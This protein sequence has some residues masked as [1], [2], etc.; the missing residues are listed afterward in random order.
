MYKFINGYK[1]KLIK[2]NDFIRCVIHGE[3]EEGMSF[4][5][6]HIRNVNDGEHSVN[7]RND[8]NFALVERN[9]DLMS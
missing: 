5:W 7:V 4:M 2:W 6:D 1:Q 9:S 8:F 3:T